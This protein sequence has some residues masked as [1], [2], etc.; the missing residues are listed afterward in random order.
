VQL[1]DSITI[2]RE[3]GRRRRGKQQTWT[4]PAHCDP[5]TDPR[6]QRPGSSLP[7]ASSHQPTRATRTWPTSEQVMVWPWRSFVPILR[8]AQARAPKA[9][10]GVTVLVRAPLRRLPAV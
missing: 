1:K 5:S 4:R 2:D 8:A 9:G 6:Q 7:V 10:N 3:R